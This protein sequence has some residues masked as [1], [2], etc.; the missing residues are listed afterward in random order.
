VLENKPLRLACWVI[1]L[2]PGLRIF[3]FEVSPSNVIH[4]LGRA[5]KRAYPV[6][7]TLRFVFNAKETLSLA[8]NKGES[9][10]EGSDK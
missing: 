2:D 1:T 3:P 4:H 8:T 9:K 7:V 6:F 5:A 10:S